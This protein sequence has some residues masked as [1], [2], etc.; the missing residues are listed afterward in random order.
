MPA[1]LA[2]ALNSPTLK[3]MPTPPLAA[4]LPWVD[5]QRALRALGLLVPALAC[6]SLAAYA[7]TGAWWW[8]WLA[9]LLTFIVVPVLDRWIGAD[10]SNP[11]EA[12]VPALNGDRYYERLVVALVPLQLV[13]TV[14]GAWIVV[15]LQPD[16]PAWLGL[17]LTVGGVNGFG[18][19]SAHEM[20][21]KKGRIWRSLAQAGLAPSAY[22][23]FYVEHNRGHH[24]NVATPCDPASSR[25][26]QSFWRFLPRT[27]VGSVR[28]AWR[29]ERSRLARLGRGPWSLA[30]QNLQGWSMTLLLFGGL[31][32]WLGTAALV[33]L[34]LQA[35]YAAS[36]LE[37]VNYLEHYGLLRPADSQGRPVRC[38]PEHSWNSNHV[39]SNLLLYQLQRHSDHH[40]H[41]ARSYQALRHFDTSPQLPSGYASMLLLAYVPWLWF[42]VMDPLVVR[43]CGGDLDRANVEPAAR[44]RLYRLY[45]RPPA[46]AP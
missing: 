32:A 31:V 21:H 19:V 18:I 44:Q 11:P 15:A 12:A 20:G 30:N 34:L 3:P 37:V 38:G 13:A 36:L 26:G 24:H 10:H 8:C 2:L 35:V 40:A 1:A 6:L 42:A 23:H 46:A 29:L 7:G 27:I 39:V 33:F 17:L 14:G 41:A 5:K 28:S 4:E 45:H 22:G 16:W 9:P 25:M 43:H